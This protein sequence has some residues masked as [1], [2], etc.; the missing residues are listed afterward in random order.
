[1]IILQAAMGLGL[2]IIFIFK[3]LIFLILPLVTI[4]LTVKNYKK[5]K[6]ENIEPDKLDIIII[7]LKSLLVSIGIIIMGALIIFFLLYLTVD[8]TYS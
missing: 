2:L 4:I 7:I 1:M 6:S 5:A 3:L 8:L